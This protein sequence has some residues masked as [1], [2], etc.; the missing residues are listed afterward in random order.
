MSV[1]E[2]SNEERQWVAELQAII[3]KCPSD[4]LAAYA[5]GDNIVTLY[6]R[7][8]V[9]AY[10]QQ[11]PEEAVHTVQAHRKLGTVLGYI[12]MPFYVRCI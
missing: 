8:T 4:R 1:K 2:L 11:Y 7:P 10:Q 12:T 6:D 3:N 5:I 9:Q